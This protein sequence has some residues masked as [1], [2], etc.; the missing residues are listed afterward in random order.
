[1]EKE[2]NKGE[3]G[4]NNVS[5]NME[6]VKTISLSDQE[7]KGEEQLEKFIR[8][9]KVGEGTYAIVYRAKNKENRKI[10]ALKEIRME[11]TGEEGVPFT[12]IREISLLKR[13]KHPNIVRLHQVINTERKGM[14]LVLNLCIVI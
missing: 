8:E 2:E 1:M 14:T 11:S 13:L 3:N 10:Y 7:E 9:K 12:V 5:V 6:D 4:N